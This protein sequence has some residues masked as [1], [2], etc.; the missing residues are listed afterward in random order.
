M[1]LT[2]PFSPA[3]RISHLHLQKPPIS[4]QSSILV[5]RTL[6]LMHWTDTLD[7]WNPHPHPQHRTPSP[8]L[9]AL[10]T[11]CSHPRVPPAHP[12]VP[13]GGLEGPSGEE[14][15]L[16]KE[17][18]EYIRQWGCSLTG[19]LSFDRPKEVGSVFRYGSLHQLGCP[20]SAGCWI[21]SVLGLVWDRGQQCWLLTCLSWFTEPLF[22]LCT[23]CCWHFFASSQPWSGHQH[24]NMSPEHC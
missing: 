17:G 8:F 10:V 4:P 7:P 21:F 1:V 5:H 23:H 13:L 22:P 24:C 18:A 19:A 6:T 11:A 14:G 15:L 2:M 12:G 3:H 9:V 16:D 20:G